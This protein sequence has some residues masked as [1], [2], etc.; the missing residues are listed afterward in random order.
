MTRENLCNDQYHMRTN[1]CATINAIPKREDAIKYA[2]LIA[3]VKMLLSSSQATN[4]QE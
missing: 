3:G 4:H 2:R 1:N